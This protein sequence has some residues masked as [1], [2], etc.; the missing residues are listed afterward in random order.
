MLVNNMYF[1]ERSEE[2]TSYRGLPG[3]LAV[4]AATVG[5]VFW[6]RADAFHDYWQQTRHQ[7]SGLSALNAQSWWASGAKLSHTLEQALTVPAEWQAETRERMVTAV[8][9]LMLG[10]EE[11]LAGEKTAPEPVAVVT[12]SQ[13]K[14]HSDAIH[15]PKPARTNKAAAGDT[16][17]KVSAPEVVAASGVASTPVA[18]SSASQPASSES[19][20]VRHFV[21]LGPDGRLVLNENDRV[22]LVGDSMMQGVAPHLAKA[23]QKAHVKAIDASKQSTGLTYPTYFDW[24]EKIRELIPKEKIS[25]LV[26]MMGAND[27]WD[28]VLAGKYERFGSERWRSIYAQRVASILQFA[29]SQHVR[30]IWLGAPNMGKE[31]VNNGVRLLNQ[32]YASAMTD[33]ISRFVSTREALSD[34]ADVY[35]RYITKEDGTSVVVRSEDGVHFTRDGH[36]ILTQLVLKQLVLPTPQPQS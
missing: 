22:L 19:N 13:L 17:Q 24:P 5:L 7:D 27:T 36:K 10:K 16:G 2:E 15:A 26:V 4:L 12:A 25:V 33:G 18:D 34:N 28:M 3:T 11:V 32:L 29:H 35:Q 9:V 1:G 31:K 23:L 14:L 8:N 6:C 21:K 20:E 30:V